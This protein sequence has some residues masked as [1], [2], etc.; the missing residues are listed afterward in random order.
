MDHAINE[1][2]GA[3]AEGDQMDVEH[4]EPTR[5]R[6]KVEHVAS[7]GE[8]VGSD[9][10]FIVDSEGIVTALNKTS[11]Q[12]KY[13]SNAASSRPE[14]IDSFSWT[15]LTYT[16]ADTT[17]PH[18]P[19]A[20][21]Q[22]PTLQSD[23]S[24]SYS[25][26]LHPDAEIIKLMHEELPKKRVAVVSGQG[27]GKDSAHAGDVIFKDADQTKSPCQSRHGLNKE[28]S[29][30][31]K[32]QGFGFTNYHSDTGFKGEYE[33]DN[34]SELSEAPDDLFSDA[35]SALPESIAKSSFSTLEP[36][37]HDAADL[38]GARMLASLHTC[39]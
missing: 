10:A 24:E 29:V 15:Q 28:S 1:N 23:I 14:P 26:E 25:D 4:Q 39:R 8:G 12:S 2:P 38:D 18:A 34:D 11:K 6:Q 30:R 33:S 32:S 20:L 27:T 37:V 21:P 35:F 7:D 36:C 19:T 22:A 17:L 13:A 3:A 16:I 9:R 5:K 31:V